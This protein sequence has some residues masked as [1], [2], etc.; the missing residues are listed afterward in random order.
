MANEITLDITETITK[1][2]VTED[3]TSI[4]IT[5]NI[6]SVELKGISIS[7]A[8]SATAMAY[9]GESNTLGYGSTVAASLDHIN[10]NGFNKNLDQTIDGNIT[11]AGDTRH[12][13]F[14]DTNTFI[15]EH[16]T[17]NKLELRGGGS[18]SSE[19]VY[20]D[21]SGSVGIGTSTPASKLDVVGTIT[22]DGGTTSADLNFGDDNKAT[23]GSS[24]DLRIY[25]DTASFESP[26]GGKSVI[27][28]VGTNGL[29]ISS[30]GNGIFL[31]NDSKQKA[32]AAFTLAGTSPFIR[33]YYNN[34]LRL[35]TTAN[36]VAV[37][38]EVTATE[39]ME[40]PLFKGDLEGAVHFKAS[41]SGLAK[42]D[43]V[44]ISGYAGQKTTVDKADASDPAKMPAFGIVNATQGNNNVDILTFG[45]ML[46][47]STTGIATG[48]EL[49]VS[50]STPGG[51]EASA[52]TGEGNLV[53][54]IAKVVRGDSNSGSIK[55]MGAGRTNATP[56]LNDGNIF[57]GNSSNISTTASFDTTFASSFA[58]R[59]TTDLTE[60]DNEYFTSARA[61]ARVDL[62]TGSNLD[63]SQKTTTE[64]AEGANE[65]FT[66]ARADARVNTVLGTGVD[67]IVT[68]GYLRGPSTFTIDPSGHGDNT[69]KV[70]IAG[71]LQVDGTTTTI[72]ST[73]L[74]ID[75][76]VIE[77]ASN[78]TNTSEANGAGISV[79]GTTANIA[80]TSSFDGWTFN[81]SI[82]LNGN[83][84]LSGSFSDSNNSTGT[85]GQALL[86]TGTATEWGDISTTL[87]VEADSGDTQSIAMLTENLDIAGGTGI[88]TATTDN[89][90]TVKLDDTA[91]T[92]GTY[93]AA[94][95]VP[96]ITVDAQGRI[97]SLSNITG[98][99]G[100]RGAH[101]AT[102]FDYKFSRN[103][104]A[105]NNPSTYMSLS[106]YDYTASDLKLSVNYTDNNSNDLTDLIREV[107]TVNSYV[108]LI[109]NANPEKFVVL[110]I[111]DAHRN[112]SVG[113]GDYES[114]VVSVERV[115]GV[116]GSTSGTEYQNMVAGLAIGDGADLPSQPYITTA[117][118]KA[119][120][121]AAVP[122]G[123]FNYTNNYDTVLGISQ[124]VSGGIAFNNWDYEAATS[125]SLS[126]TDSNSNNIESLI[127]DLLGSNALPVKALITITNQL[128]PSKYVTFE[129]DTISGLNAE[130]TDY[131]T[132]AVDYTSGLTGK[133]SNG[134]TT[135]SEGLVPLYGVGPGPLA[136]SILKLP[137]RS[138]AD[139][140]GIVYGM[141]YANDLTASLPSGQIAVSSHAYTSA[142]FQM[143][144][145]S[146]S[147][148]NT[149]VKDFIRDSS[150]S[151]STPKG[152]LRLTS[153]IDNEYSLFEIDGIADSSSDDYTILD[154][155]HISGSQGG[156]AYQP[157]DL[158]VVSLQN[159]ADVGA[160]GEPGAMPGASF[161]YGHS[162]LMGT[163]NFS[164][165]TIQFNHWNYDSAST[166][167]ISSTDNDSVN[168]KDTIRFLTGAVGVPN[169]GYV[170][171]TN[172]AN[173]SRYVVFEIE[174]LHES[175]NTDISDNNFTTIDINR[176]AGLTGT[177]DQ[178]EIGTVGPL[179]GLGSG[180]LVVSFNRAADAAPADPTAL[181]YKFSTQNT[182]GSG[183][184]LKL[185]VSNY[186]TGANASN[187]RVYLPSTDINSL[188]A[189]DFIRHMA[190]SDATSKGYIRIS[191]IY[192]P[193]DLTTFEI[194]GIADESDDAYTVLNITHAFGKD[195]TAQ[196]GGVAGHNEYVQVTFLRAAD[197]GDIDAHL[198]VGGAS[199]G[200][201]LSWNGS[202]YAWVDDQ[203]GGSTRTIKVDTDGDGTVNETL[204]AAEDL[205]LKAGTNVTLAE[206]GGVVTINSSGGG[207]SGTA[208]LVQDADG[209][210]KIQV[211]EATDEDIIRFDIAG[212]ELMTLDA[213]ELELKSTD[214][215][216]TGSGTG[217]D[218]SSTISPSSTNSITAWKNTGKSSSTGIDE[219][220]HSVYLSPNGTTLVFNTDSPTGDSVVKQTLS[221]AF[222]ISTAGSTVSDSVMSGV[223]SQDESVYDLTF[224]T[225]GSKS[226]SLTDNSGSHDRKVVYCEPST[227][228]GPDFG[229]VVNEY[230]YSIY[231]APSDLFPNS[232]DF[233]TD[234]TKVFFGGYDR[235]NSSDFYVWSYTLSNA[236]DLSDT[237]TG[238]STNRNVNVSM[239]T[240]KINL[241]SL[242]NAK[243]LK[244]NSLDSVKFSS[245]GKT[246]YI[247][248]S[249]LKNIRSFALSIAWDLTST[250]T[251]S[252]S[253]K[254]SVI[255]STPKALCV[256][257]ANNIAL[258]SG[259]ISEKITQFS[260]DHSTLQVVSE[261][262]SFDGNLFAAGALQ[263]DGDINLTQNLNTSNTL[264]ERVVLE[265]SLE[266]GSSFIVKNPDTSGDVNTVH[267]VDL[268]N[269]SEVNFSASANG[270][271]PP[272]SV[273]LP[274]HKL[275]SG[276]RVLY[277]SENQGDALYLDTNYAIVTGDYI[278]FGR[279]LID[280]VAVP[281][282]YRDL[283][284]PAITN[285]DYAG[286]N[287]HTF[288]ELKS[289]I[290]LRGQDIEIG[291]SEVVDSK[292]SISN[293]GG[294]LTNNYINL[295]DR[296]TAFTTSYINIGN[297]GAANTQNINIGSAQSTVAQNI[298]LYGSI[299]MQG[300]NRGSGDG[301]H[302]R[303]ITIGGQYTKGT[304]TLGES[305]LTNTINIGSS[306][307]AGNT[308]N[309]NIGTSSAGTTNISL[310]KFTL[311]TSDGNANQVL[312]TDG[313]GNLDFVTQSGGGSVR[314]VS[315]ANA[316]NLTATLLDSEDLVLVEG[317]N[318]TISET[319]GAVT[320]NAPET[321]GAIDIITGSLSDTQFKA[322]NG[323]RLLK[324]ASG[325]S[326]EYDLFQPTA[327]DIGK[328]W[329][330]I[331]ADASGSSSFSSILIESNGQRVRFL[332]GSSN[333]AYGSTVNASVHRG[334]I[335]EIVCI[336]AN[337]NG[338]TT[339][340]PNFIIYGSGIVVG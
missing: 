277:S 242:L 165:G 280:A 135:D 274:G 240:N 72:N 340:A 33:L 172:K 293:I 109:N 252:G 74:T 43:V 193:G 38:G 164:A 160:K 202:D 121:L 143:K 230:R 278:Q 169:K 203:T 32:L 302:N 100:P 265:T 303:S 158:V 67:N 14:G 198:N 207:G 226:F 188:S 61:D 237:S 191:N 260:L 36:G 326:Y 224:S 21:N 212:T 300:S 20:I 28:D 153:L 217:S 328:S 295:N 47:L 76:K 142:N 75:D 84:L 130:L 41:G 267:S 30:N 199:N 15:G 146:T 122:A 321:P 238:T 233:K 310:G 279:R 200:Q 11:F 206:A 308:Q 48:T 313:N 170:T 273:Y 325:G 329:T 291:G 241:T 2:E 102:T 215:K 116:L 250:V 272:Y 175:G 331:N 319:G 23:F 201:I 42:G 1:V 22:F 299:T 162:Q 92:A 283:Q 210:T 155:T 222:D 269:S 115:A 214:L 264:S 261:A 156:V 6:T 179:Y 192:K 59:T 111:T 117:F 112:I 66:S 114:L 218:L 138:L 271:A 25:H 79:G 31:E 244:I 254:I 44:Y 284:N 71:D 309:I 19:T 287:D 184:R 220:V 285:S 337:A 110:K 294:F 4:N 58:T 323:K 8:G 70:V 334:G 29:H 268:S 194:T 52:P 171:V 231:H 225:D 17:S 129:V 180:P 154:L 128:N 86:S 236:F 46:H 120:E 320:F 3:V 316:N 173:P 57:I 297:Q 133:D 77:V 248:D 148:E 324:I 167:K 168:V 166:L 13:Y 101:A 65:Y 281:P 105:S 216:I 339:A 5:P 211:E 176:V 147:E 136:V 127:E 137:N 69:G 305:D 161:E 263:I 91:V 292:I 144:L 221:T 223:A 118:S 113:S 209:D 54:K 89:T 50:A 249:V 123:S 157:K 338:G 49:Y 40:A 187:L 119:G 258:I 104:M 298:T 82:D 315:T 333:F 234:G 332:S 245:D 106:S 56:N 253:Q 81:K 96:Q 227:A 330:V 251:S 306:I 247:L 78:A 53:Q 139:T 213:N 26:L 259:L 246:F 85:A 68:T 322:K 318:I 228:F 87:N 163:T 219:Q 125:I 185:S 62:Q 290:K 307:T 181:T 55:I 183:D 63:L 336:A 235:N 97:T 126:K 208:G 317:T 196:T 39:K 124:H 335:A 186:Y 262:A 149:S 99:T 197:N 229:T 16:S 312:K 239:G 131:F 159:A 150:T 108:T 232:I 73:E 88:S 60:G 270:N 195:G 145:H 34:S 205:V 24:N 311:P 93:G 95:T 9:A 275:K 103:D 266:S 80:Y 134:D 132:L 276:D 45:S 18:L 257:T 289:E 51:Y 107:T 282:I 152:Y 327:A 243:N 189:K 288:K 178:G 174:G 27:E 182:M 83:L 151:T 140:T 286:Q 304:I 255:E 12:I 64:L 301:T 98:N 35:E 7:N 204:D 177:N 314:T 90:V 141:T 94:E 190:G 296:A 10:T 37:T 256:D